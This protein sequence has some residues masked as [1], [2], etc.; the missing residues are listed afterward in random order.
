MKTNFLTITQNIN[1]RHKL[2]KIIKT[3]L[4]QKY[5]PRIFSII[6]FQ[7]KCVICTSTTKYLHELPVSLVAILLELWLYFKQ[8]VSIIQWTL[9]ILQWPAIFFYRMIELPN[10]D[11]LEFMQNLFFSLFFFS[12]FFKKCTANQ[13]ICLHHSDLLF[14]F[15]TLCLYKMKYS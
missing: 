2:A 9:K 14:D 15:Y 11:N 13:P 8:N 12:L 1:P 5:Q 10:Y 3:S 4:Y 7:A 6:Y